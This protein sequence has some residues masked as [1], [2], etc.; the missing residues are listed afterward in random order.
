YFSDSVTVSQSE[1][2]RTPRPFLYL[3]EPEP[4]SGEGRRQPEAEPR[5]GEGRRQPEAA[6]WGARCFVSL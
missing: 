5:S 3:R 6:E 4:R 2:K 1:R